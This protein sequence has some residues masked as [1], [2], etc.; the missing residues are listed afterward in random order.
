[1]AFKMMGGKDPKG[2]TGNGIPGSLM[3]GPKMKSCGGPMMNEPSDKDKI[4]KAIN[5]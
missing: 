1:M 2:K 5:E 4:M 3:G